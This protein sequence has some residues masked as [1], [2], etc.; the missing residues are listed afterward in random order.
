MAKKGS[1]TET[2]PMTWDQ[3]QTLISRLAKDIE[4]QT[5]N[6]LRKRQHVKF[7]LLIAIGC[8]TG[9]RISDLLALSWD[10][11]LN[12]DSIVLKEIKTGK[13]RTLTINEN[14]KKLLNKY[15][16]FIKPTTYNDMLFTDMNDNGVMTIQYINRKLKLILA[17]YKIKVQNASS[18][19]FRKTFGLRVY[20]LN[21]KSDDALITLSQIFN[22][23]NT[24]VTR[25][26]I[27][28]QGKKIENVYLSL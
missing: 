10:D 20:E 7:L 5:E 22:H 1:S 26:Y 16:N 19:V 23:A 17:K 11:L 2:S 27:G 24:Q 14:L 13:S 18:H 28:L 6:E 15:V 25:A 12:R 3:F 9:L 4:H 8:Y 21:F